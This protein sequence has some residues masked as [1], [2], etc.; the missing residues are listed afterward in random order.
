MTI[1]DRQSTDPSKGGATFPLSHRIQRLTWNLVW[2]LFGK[3]SPVPFFGWR[4][5]LASSFGARL[6]QK[7]R[8][9]PG[10]SIWHPRNL[11]MADYACLGWRVNCY[12][13]DLIKLDEF[14]LVSQ[15]AE[16]CAG[17]HNVDEDRFQLVTKPIIIGRKAWVAAGAFVGPGVVI[18]DGAVLGARAVTMKSLAPKTIYA[19]NPARPIR[20]R[21]IDIPPHD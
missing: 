12:C 19:G 11:E 6:T 5:W 9:Y 3:W 14:A 10:V 8:I 1:L 15:D 4:R 20:E 16:L 21:T 2:G 17:T 7:A 13:M 18:G